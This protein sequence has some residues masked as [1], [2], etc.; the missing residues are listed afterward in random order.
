[1]SVKAATQTPDVESDP[2]RV[3]LLEATRVLLAQYGPRKLAL[4]DIAALASVSRPTLY[5]HFGSKDELLVAL[6]AY[7]Q[8]QFALGL[9]AATSGTSGSARLDAAL[10]HVV[11]FQRDYPFQQ[12][13]EIEPG[14]MLDQLTGVLPVLRD[15]LVPLVAEHLRATA[16]TARAGDV[17]DLVVRVALSHFLI[18][19]RDRNQLLR[20]L[21][22]AAAIEKGT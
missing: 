8:A 5:K 10:R 13:V 18:P 7:E 15:G 12:L 19:G 3:R 20:E 11:D 2:V 22:H 4:T 21:R 6:S 17:A 16:S 1:M 14:F 9:R